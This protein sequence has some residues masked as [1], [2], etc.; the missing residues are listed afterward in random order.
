MMETVERTTVHIPLQE[1]ETE[2]DAHRLVAKAVAPWLDELTRRGLE[3][4]RWTFFL[5]DFTG[6]GGAWEQ[7]VMVET[8]CRVIPSP[9]DAERHWPIMG[10][11]DD[12]KDWGCRDR[13]A[14][15]TCGGP[16]MGDPYGCG[17]CCGC[18]GGCP[19]EDVERPGGA[20]YVW[21]GD[22]A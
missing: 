8:W 3:P 14:Y 11:N 4:Q 13:C 21:E 20:P 12:P 22:Q 2:D 19:V 6:P 5:Q 9:Y 7:T 18:L 10:L 17:G 15:G 1:L 16:S